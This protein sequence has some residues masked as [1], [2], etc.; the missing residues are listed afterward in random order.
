[1]FFRGITHGQVK[2]L[3][4]LLGVPALDEHTSHPS[5]YAMET[6]I[7]WTKAKPLSVQEQH[8]VLADHFRR[9]ELNY[10][11]PRLQ[12]KERYTAISKIIIM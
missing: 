1:M 9:L 4:L 3:A 2:T 11:I 8:Q 5:T 7:E 12:G 6:V 10:L